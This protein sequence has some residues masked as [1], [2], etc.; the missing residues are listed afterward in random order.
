MPISFTLF[1]TCTRLS[2]TTCIYYKVHSTRDFFCMY[3]KYNRSKLNKKYSLKLRRFKV[4]CSLLIFFFFDSMIMI[5]V[6]QDITCLKEQDW[7]LILH[8]ERNSLPFL[9]MDTVQ[10][11]V[12]LLCI[13]FSNGNH[14]L[15][16]SAIKMSKL[17]FF[18]I[19]CKNNK[20]KWIK[21]RSA[22]LIA[23]TRWNFRNTRSISV[24]ENEKKKRKRTTKWIYKRKGENFVKKGD[25][26]QP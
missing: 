26:Y 14:S 24:K 8:V 4:S 22:M 1:A 17:F 6:W 10:L 12:Q 20:D 23:P 15:V 5:K 25:I 2:F 19:H 9:V 18:F 3:L 7:R 11:L 16:P 21:I 13:S